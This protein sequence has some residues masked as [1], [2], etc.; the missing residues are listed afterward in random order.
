MYSWM[1]GGAAV[2]VCKQLSS[3]HNNHIKESGQCQDNA[4]YRSLYY[5]RQGE[6]MLLLGLVC[7]SVNNMA[8]VCL[9]VS[10]QHYS[11][12]LLM[13]FDE[14]FRIARQRYQEQLIK[15]WGSFRSISNE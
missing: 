11:N 1:A 6:V 15:V 5:Q 8:F 4:L 9:S 7:L 13:D 2:H 10:Q 3:R 14:N 12:K